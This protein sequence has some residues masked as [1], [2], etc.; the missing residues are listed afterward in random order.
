MAY[1]ANMLSMIETTVV[2]VGGRMDAIKKTLSH[3]LHSTGRNI[4]SNGL[5][6]QHN[7]EEMKNEKS[8]TYW[9]KISR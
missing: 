7:I 2:L 9:G 6:F 1:L 4:C 3:L 5:I 8:G